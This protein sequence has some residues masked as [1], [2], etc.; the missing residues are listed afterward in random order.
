MSQGRGYDLAV[1]YLARLCCA[2]VVNRY[3]RE[4]LD[5]EQY[6]MQ[7]SVPETTQPQVAT[8]DG[9]QSPTIIAANG[10]RDL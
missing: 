9:K 3:G 10:F 5:L 6:C 4:I 2:I 8:T 7:A 1:M